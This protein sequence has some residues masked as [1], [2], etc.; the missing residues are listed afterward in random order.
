MSDAPRHAPDF[1][2]VTIAPELTKLLPSDFMNRYLVIP[3]DQQG[4]R[5]S[6][7][8]SDPANT[9]ALDQI[10]SITGFDVD[11]FGCTPEAIQKLLQKFAETAEQSV[12]HPDLVIKTDSEGAIPII[13][14]KLFELAL[15]HRASDI[16]LEPQAE[17]FFVRFRIDGTLCTIHEFPRSIHGP[18]VSRIKVMAGMDITEKRMPQDGQITTSLQKKEI[19]LRVST[20]PGK[21][22]EKVVIRLL[23][24][25][26]GLMDLSTFG[27]HP[28]MESQ[29]EMLI[30]KPQGLLL[31]T[32]PTGSGKSTTLYAVLKRLK[33]PHKNIITL[34]DPVEYE[35][36]S[37]KKKE[38]G[39]TQVQMHPKIGLTFA[40]GLRASLRQDPD[41][42]MVGEIRDL[43][44]AE[45]SMKAAMTG[46]FVLSTLHTNDAPSA[47][48]RLRDIGVEPYL[49]S[50]TLTGVMA[51]RLLR[52]LCPHCKE[53]YE[54]PLRALQNLFPHHSPEKSIRLYRPQGCDQCK[55]TGYWGRKGIYELLVLNDSLRRLIHENASSEDIRKLAISQG[56]K[57][58]RESGIELVYQ[59]LTTVEEVFRHTVD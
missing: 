50:S 44:T 13:V 30:E 4:G 7:A 5:L 57:T 8:I 58:L 25:S 12:L 31:V 10:R 26:G 35:L 17:A 46:H 34:E 49:I 45:V 9:K 6:V 29:F 41:V 21:H 33:S 59:G 36:L 54:P 52:L 1:S 51:Q 22:G 42:I 24:K 20:L 15:Q 53:G 32:G 56:L 2:Q 40:A 3:F 47:I 16:H 23:D 27:L 55:K 19:D 43:E 38:S 39:I 11:S 14:D 28:A 37:A 48:G 18:L